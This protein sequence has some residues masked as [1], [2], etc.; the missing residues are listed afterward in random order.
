MTSP[1]KIGICE[2]EIKFE[3]VGFWFREESSHIYSKQM[4]RDIYE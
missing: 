3:Q 2:G 4:S 1:R